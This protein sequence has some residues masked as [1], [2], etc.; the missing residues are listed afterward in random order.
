M[1]FALPT[2]M[3]DLYVALCDVLDKHPDLPAHNVGHVLLILTVQLARS[4]RRVCPDPEN[5][6]LQKEALLRT[7]ALIWDQHVRMEEI[8][9][10]DRQ[11]V[12]AFLNQQQKD[13]DN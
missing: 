2:P 3:H 8:T 4:A 5:Q 10:D 6:S 11:Q 7:C 13:K 1:T 12:L 9:S